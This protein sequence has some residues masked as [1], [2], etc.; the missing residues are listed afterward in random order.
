MMGWNT[1]YTRSTCTCYLSKHKSTVK[2]VQRQTDRNLMTTAHVSAKLRA[3][4]SSCYSGAQAAPWYPV[5]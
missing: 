2:T 4:L 5:R 1:A 3:M